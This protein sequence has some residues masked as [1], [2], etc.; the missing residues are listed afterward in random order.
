MP[1]QSQTE[2]PETLGNQP[3]PVCHK[4]T[5]TLTELERDIPYFGKTFFFSMAC[6][7]CDYYKTDIESA[8]SREPS[9]FTVEICSEEDMKIR[10]VRSS[11]ATI[12]IPHITTITP[13][14]ASSGYVTNIEGILSRVKHQIEAVR[15]NEE[16]K[17]GKKKAKNLLKKLQ[18]IMWGQ[19]KIKIIIEDP[20]GNS[21]ILS[22]KAVKTKL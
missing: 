12:K 3:C 22:E 4:K 2:A 1:K 15:D 14:P 9:K 13:G 21:G 17:S 20:T 7:N 19:E 8:E 16:E 6:S 18:R 10:I 5:L 11:Q